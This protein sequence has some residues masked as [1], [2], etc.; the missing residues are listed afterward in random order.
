MERKVHRLTPLLKAWTTLAALAVIAAVNFYEPLVNWARAEG[1]GLGD[2]A[3]GVG[4][5]A[6]G[7]AVLF[8]IS[9]LWWARMGFGIGE[10]ELGLKRGVVTTH[11]RTARFERIQAVDVVEPFVARI[12]GLAAVRVEAAG[13]ADSA[14]EIAYLPKDEAERVRVEIMRAVA[15][16][17]ADVDAGAEDFLVS[18]V[19]IRRTLLGTLLR[20]ST[21]IA[22]AFTAIP[23]ATSLSPAAAIPVLIG[24]FPSVWRMVDQSWRFQA[25]RGDEVVT[26]TYGL[27]NRRRQAVP[28]D[29]IHAVSLTQPPL[30]RP[31]G[32]WEVKVNVAGYKTAGDGGT[33]TLLPVGTLAEALA[34]VRALSPLQ[35]G[36]L[37]EIDPAT[38][39]VDVRTPRRARW[40]SPVDWHRQSLVLRDGT[41]V[42]TSG[43]LS[44]RYAVVEV[45]HIQEL[46]YTQGP[47]RRA[48]GLAHV[49]LD[50]V[51]GPVGATVRD[52]D[53]ERARLVVDT[54]RARAL[55]PV[56]R[57]PIELGC[58]AEQGN[59]NATPAREG[60]DASGAAYGGGGHHGAQGVSPDQAR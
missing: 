30:W 60:E 20:V 46:T 57:A 36:E 11:V 4:I 58:G 19:P 54:L 9:Q 42:V 17:G 18:P 33:L 16:E 44:R 24:V 13:G 10:E 5:F 31:L 39:D 23:L 43:A 56:G 3:R 38:A 34:V 27:A 37:A 53:F 21:L 6:A 2:L 35:V 59:G 50:L 48:L 22:A 47:L 32:W 40:V 51:P 12:F 8:G 55:P 29:R 52:L 41:A 15:R 1:F 28:L 26:V 25:V 45:P 49:R 14:I 7:I